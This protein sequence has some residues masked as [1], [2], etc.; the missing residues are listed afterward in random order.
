MERATKLLVVVWTCVAL[1]ADAWLLRHPWPA[2]PLLAAGALVG[3]ALATALDR[4]AVG[5]V[6]VFA[7][8]FPALIA[9]AHGTFHVDFTVIWLAALLGAML[10]DALRTEWHLPVG[11]RAPLVCWALVIAVA[12]P[13]VVC[14][15]M[16]FYPALLAEPR[17]ANA[18]SGG[19]GPVFV[20]RWVLQV[21]VALVLGI[22]WFDWLCGSSSI[23]F[24]RAI[25]SPLAVSALALA[26]VSIYQLFG[27]F[28]F[29]NGN[30][31]GGMGRASG[32]VFDA[33]VAG[34]VAALWTGGFLL[35][36]RG[37]GRLR[38]PLV[39]VGV[40]VAW[41]A[42]W[43]SGSRTALLS[44]LIV[45]ASSIVGVF[46]AGGRARVF[47]WRQAVAAGALVA[48]AVAV[49]VFANINQEVVGPVQR[50]RETLPDA[51]VQGWRDFGRRM[52]DRDGY[53][54]AATAMIREFPW[55]G[56]GVGAFHMMGPEY[57]PRELNLIPDNAQNWYR[58][59]L[60]E[61]GLMGSLPWLVWVAVFGWYVV[62]RRLD[63]RP[64]AWTA[65]GMLMGLAAVSL[66]GMPAQSPVVTLTFWTVAFWFVLLAGPPPSRQGKLSGR[67]W[68][69]IGSLILVFA[70]GTAHLAATRLRVPVRAQSNGWSYAYGFYAPEPD[71]EGGEI[72][73]AKQRA[74]IVLEATDRWLELSVGVNH[75]DVETRPVDVRVWLDGALAADLT[76]SSVDP[77]TRTFPVPAGEGRVLLETWVSRAVRPREL[78]VDDGRE[79]GLRVKWGFLPTPAGTGRADTASGSLSGH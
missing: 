32:T 6:L 27:D 2:L 55:F 43:A 13:I 26:A 58:H 66:V 47:R 8:V 74:A 78:G 49:L 33:N 73:W 42:V 38:I 14:R 63:E 51:S 25:A 53:G 69:L 44:G 20:I 4:R 22:L 11:W 29:L 61:F 10:P 34:A 46:A 31:F 3:A 77:V 62:T 16:D 23:D 7:Y 67:T 19:G 71:G 59:Q 56:V 76:L 64:D 17:L 52:W 9:I 72:R 24:H 30:V 57:V 35:W 60:V 65:R 79:L 40:A 39:T 1:A 54:Q 18:L 70:L 36:G 41:L 12:T 21:A 37:L 5:I 50:L 45:A 28:M 15:E 48:V 75:L 68:A